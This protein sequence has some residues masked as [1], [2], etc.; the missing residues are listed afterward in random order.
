MY[1]GGLL[2]SAKQQIST[3]KTKAIV[4]NRKRVVYPLQFGGEVLPQVEEFRY[5]GVRERV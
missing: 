5:L 4:L 2:P 1:W 3:S